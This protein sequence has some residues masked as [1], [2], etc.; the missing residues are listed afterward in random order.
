[1]LPALEKILA[2]WLRRSLKDAPP[3]E[4]VDKGKAIFEHH[5]DNHQHCGLW[6]T[7]EQ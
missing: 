3:A 4:H 6:E 7:E 2:T 5:F 1:M